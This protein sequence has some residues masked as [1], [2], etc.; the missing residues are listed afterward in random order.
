MEDDRESG[1]A[2]FDLLEDVEAD[3][4]I[5]AGFEL[6]GA[7]AG[8][9]GDG[10]GVDAGAVQ[11]RLNFFRTGVGV[12]LGLDFVFDAGEDAEFAFDRHVELVR[13]FDDLLGQGDVVVE[14]LGGAS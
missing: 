9:D 12:L 11:E 1:D 6:V 10:E 14:G 5:R 8:A 7:V 13:V 4:G 3:A 2:L